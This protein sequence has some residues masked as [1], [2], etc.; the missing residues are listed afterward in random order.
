M[1]RR[2]GERRWHVRALSRAA[3][4]TAVYPKRRNLAMNDLQLDLQN[5]ILLIGDILEK[6]YP[7]VNLTPDQREKIEDA[8]TF[9]ELVEEAL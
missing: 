8:Q 9:L 3:R 5:V 6:S 2:Q 4:D 1:Q 7:A